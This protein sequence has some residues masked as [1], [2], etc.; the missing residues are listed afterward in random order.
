MTCHGGDEDYVA[1]RS[2]NILPDYEWFFAH[3]VEQRDMGLALR[4]L[5]EEP[6]SELCRARML[7]S[8][9]FNVSEVLSLCNKHYR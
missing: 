1:R 8:G 3:K 9:D 5:F 6:M 7:I 2:K 4:G